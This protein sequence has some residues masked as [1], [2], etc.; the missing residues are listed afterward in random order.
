MAT[1]LL[2]LLAP[3]ARYR[4]VPGA[5]VRAEG[6]IA[7]ASRPMRALAAHGWTRAHPSSR[8]RAPTT[9]PRLE[10]AYGSA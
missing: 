6:V 1:T 2:G 3:A 8:G 5:I 7:S 10:M 4:L 9:M